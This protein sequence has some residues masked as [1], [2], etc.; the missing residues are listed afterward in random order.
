MERKNLIRSV[1]TVIGRSGLFNRAASRRGIRLASLLLV[2]VM[3]AAV[4]VLA[5]TS[6]PAQTAHA[7]DGDDHTHF[8]CSGVCPTYADVPGPRTLWSA[9]MTVGTRPNVGGQTVLGW[10]DLGRF[11]GASSAGPEFH[12]RRQ[13]IR[14][15]E[16]PI[17]K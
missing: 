3:L 9:T 13:Y 17:R 1:I 15:R 16:N 7:H 6:N 8:D 4:A 2:A 12:L 11:T 14:D 10:D 5:E